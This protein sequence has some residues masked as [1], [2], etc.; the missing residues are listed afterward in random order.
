MA[1]TLNDLSLH[2]LMPPSITEDEKV[3]AAVLAIDP[4][5]RLAAGEIGLLPILSRLDELPEAWLD[6]LAWQWHADAYDEALTIGQKRAIVRRTLIVHRYKGT[7][8]A[9]K[10]ALEGLGYDSELIEDTGLHHVFDLRIEL[11]A[12]A[13]IGAV[14]ARAVRYVESAKA[15]SRHLRSI[16][17]LLES[18]SVS[19]FG[20]VLDAGAIVEV[21]PMQPQTTTTTTTTGADFVAATTAEI[22]ID[23]Y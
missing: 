2:D 7:P 3:S 21:W 12:G 15:A 16:G 22:A 13:D 17:H 4:K 20:S 6:L 5:L 14:T 11:S 10:Q 23:M 1:K 9:V 18:D 8:Y 19:R